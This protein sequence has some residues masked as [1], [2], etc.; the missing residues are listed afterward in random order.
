MKALKQNSFSGGE[1][2]IGTRSGNPDLLLRVNA[3]TATHHPVAVADA[4]AVFVQDKPGLMPPGMMTLID[5]PTVGCWELTAHY[6]GHTLT[7]VVSV[8]LEH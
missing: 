3:S 1:V 6:G 2:L 5:I 8:E 4:S 7:F